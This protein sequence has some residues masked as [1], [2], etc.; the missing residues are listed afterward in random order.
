MQPIQSFVAW[1]PGT[2]LCSAH[3]PKKPMDAQAYEPTPPNS[4]QPNPFRRNTWG[5]RRS[6][7]GLPDRL[8]VTTADSNGFTVVK[9]WPSLPL[10]MHALRA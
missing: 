7:H 3:A 10:G 8:E 5:Y 4:T 1:L 2:L 6:L 9:L